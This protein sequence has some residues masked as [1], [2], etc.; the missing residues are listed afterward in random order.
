MLSDCVAIITLSLSYT[1]P[2]ALRPPSVAISERSVCRFRGVDVCPLRKLE[3]QPNVTLCSIYLETGRILNAHS[4]ST[5]NITHMK[6]FGKLTMS[7]SVVVVSKS[8]KV[9]LSP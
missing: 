6:M 2:S 4:Y 7:L 5:Q 1:C 9:K 3:L 8:K